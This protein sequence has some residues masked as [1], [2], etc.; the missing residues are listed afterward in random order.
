MCIGNPR[1]NPEGFME[2]IS[3]LYLDDVQKAAA[4]YYIVTV[5]KK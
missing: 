2:K 5:R 3:E 1:G 4:N